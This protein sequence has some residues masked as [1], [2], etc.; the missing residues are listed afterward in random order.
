MVK[1]LDTRII[2]PISDSVQMSPTQVVSK[3]KGMIMIKNKRK[4]LIPSKRVTGWS[5]CIDYT[6]LNDAT[7]KDHFPLAFIDQMLE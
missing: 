5:V 6:R 7:R 1:L 3:K 2:N 4:E